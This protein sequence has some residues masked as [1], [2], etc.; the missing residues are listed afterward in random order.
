MGPSNLRRM[1]SS[2]STACKHLTPT[3]STSAYHF[4]DC[5]Q[6]FFFW[7]GCG[8]NPATSRPPS[9]MSPPRG[10]ACSVCSFQ[11]HPVSYSQSWDHRLIRSSFAISCPVVVSDLAGKYKWDAW[12]KN[13]GMSKED[14]QQAYV[15]ALLEVRSSPSSPPFHNPFSGPNSNPSFHP[16]AY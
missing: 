7:Y 15:D 2:H 4:T 9:V 16:V 3:S 1:I 8:T 13:Q 12:N 11:L 10:P 5:G 6:P 14:A